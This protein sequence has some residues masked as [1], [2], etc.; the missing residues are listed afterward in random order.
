MALP[1]APETPGVTVPFLRAAHTTAE[2]EG[3]HRFRLFDESFTHSLCGDEIIP[4]DE[5]TDVA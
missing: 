4:R 1:P 2:W 3:R 5:V